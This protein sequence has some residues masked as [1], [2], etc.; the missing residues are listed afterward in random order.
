[1]TCGNR[2]GQRRQRIEIANFSPA[3][4]SREKKRLLTLIVFG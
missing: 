3:A 4:R 1:M 2:S